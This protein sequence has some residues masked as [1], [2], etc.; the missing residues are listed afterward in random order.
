MG[1]H[2][3]KSSEKIFIV[4]LVIT[5]ITTVVTIIYYEGINYNIVDAN[6]Q[7]I[8]AVEEVEELED[9]NET[10]IEE[11]VTQEIVLDQSGYLPLGKDPNADDASVVLPETMHKWNFHRTDGK[12]TVYLTFDDGP[13]TEATSKILD[14]L[15]N[16]NVKATFFTLGSAI[17]G[18]PKSHQILKRMA[19]GG[20]AIGNHGYSHKYSILYPNGVIDVKAFMN[21]MDKNVQLLKSILGKDF[22]TRVI[23]MPGGYGTWYGVTPLNAALKEKGYYQTDWNV[24]NG[25][26]EGKHKS[27]QEQLQTLKATMLD[28]DILIVLMHD[29]NE[30]ESTVQ[31]LKSG[32]DYLK[33]QGFEFKTLK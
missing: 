33:S 31:F 15:D 30:K 1:R 20:H 18:N 2:E 22:N 24:V 29:T 11:K 6:A 28:Y 21:D 26:A 19:K 13:S 27:T 3:K 9:N 4:L 14:V 23:R 12:K 8:E 16:N 10:T 7:T 17:E 25:D 5:I 32:I